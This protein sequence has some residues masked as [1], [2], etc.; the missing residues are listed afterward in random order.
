MN[1]KED[2]IKRSLSTRNIVLAALF[3]GISII[4]TRFLSLNLT[5]NMRIGLGSFPLIL[6]GIFL[7]PILGFLTGLAADL[8]GFFLN[9]VGTLHLGFTLSSGLTGLIAGLI[10]YFFSF[11]N[12]KKASIVKISLIIIFVYGLI[13]LILNSFWL[14]QLNSVP[15]NILIY[16]RSLKVIIEA[17]IVFILTSYFENRLK[18]FINN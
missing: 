14:N 1:F 12:S 9:P 7:G 3:A 11:K 4:L 15:L 16:S 10:Y 6:S 8:A 5:P 13:H 17:I 2:K 18:K